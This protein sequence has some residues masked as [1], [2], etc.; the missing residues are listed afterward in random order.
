MSKGDIYTS[1]FE[2]KIQENSTQLYCIHI[3]NDFHVLLRKVKIDLRCKD[4]K[5]KG[6]YVSVK[7]GYNDI[8]L[9]SH[10]LYYTT[11]LEVET[12]FRP[13][14]SVFANCSVVF[15]LRN[16]SSHIVKAKVLIAGINNGR[17]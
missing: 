12:N 13:G 9:C 16:L 1:G 11:H 17:A 4:T 14:Q 3:E 6:F 7:N 2:M 15:E 5:G 8:Q 10:M